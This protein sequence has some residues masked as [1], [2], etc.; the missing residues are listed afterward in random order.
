MTGEREAVQL[1]LRQ[2]APEIGGELEVEDG[3]ALAPGE[4][5]RRVDLRQPAATSA[6]GA[7]DG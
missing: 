4:Q 5:D 3:I 6:R 2:P 1:R 7:K